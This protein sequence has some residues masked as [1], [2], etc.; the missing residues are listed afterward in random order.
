MAKPARF[1][2]LLEEASAQ[3]AA[4]KSPPQLE[5]LRVKYLGRK[6]ELPAALREIATLPERQRQAAGQ[7]GNAVRQQLEQQFREAAAALTGGAAEPGSVD[8]TLPG[9]PQDRGHVHPVTLVLDE[10]D[11][12]FANLGFSKADGPEVEDDWH[13]FE[14]LN[15]GPDHPGRDMQ[16]TFYL[17]DSQDKRGIFNRLPRTQTTAVTARE[18]ESRK[19]PFRVFTLGKVFRNETEDATHAAAFHQLDAVMI[20]RDV[21]FADLKGILT[22]VIKALMGDEVAVRFRPSYFPFTEPSAE[23]DVSSPELRGGEWLEIAGAGMLHPNV[24]RNTGHN[25]KQFQSFAFALGVERIA[26]LKYGL[27]DLR[28]FFRPDVRIL[29]QF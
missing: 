21:T 28:P 24:L 19:P 5:R 23:I 12:I 18:L 10:I 22:A 17:A 9:T 29:E 3:V 4:A 15:I 20:D 25:P 8:P 6:G 16:D 14:A 1:K 26:M 13:N 27:N 7:A 11:T 2:Q